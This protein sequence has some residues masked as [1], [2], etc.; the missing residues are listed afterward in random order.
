VYDDDDSVIGFDQAV[1]SLSRADDAEEFV[2]EVETNGRIEKTGRY[3][4]LGFDVSSTLDRSRGSVWTGAGY[5]LGSFAINRDGSVAFD[6][7]FPKN[8]PLRAE[9][10]KIWKERS[11][12]GQKR[13]R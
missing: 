4:V 13:K 2:A 12:N 6:A 11:N 7:D 10:V 5:C 8:P 1:G 9:I 3:R